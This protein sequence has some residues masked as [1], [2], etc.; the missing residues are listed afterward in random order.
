MTRARTD[1]A[2]ITADL[3]AAL[4]VL[5]D[6]LQPVD[7]TPADEALCEV[8]TFCA[9]AVRLMAKSNPSKVRDVARVV[10]IKARLDGIPVVRGA[11]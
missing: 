5:R 10:E 3:A 11:A 9:V 8:E 7:G 2:E 6:A 4:R 1:V